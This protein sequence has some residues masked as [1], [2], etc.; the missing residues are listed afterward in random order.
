MKKE[1]D[2]KKDECS[3]IYRALSEKSKIFVMY[4]AGEAEE[5]IFTKGESFKIIE[6]KY[7]EYDFEKVRIGNSTNNLN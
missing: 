6:E 1:Q 3:E 2:W 5:L 7:L 4:K